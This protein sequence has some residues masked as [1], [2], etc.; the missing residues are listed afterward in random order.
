MNPNNNNIENG[1]KLTKLDKLN[2][3]CVANDKT[4]I[5]N[6]TNVQSLIKSDYF[7]MII[8]RHDFK[9]I[10]NI[11]TWKIS[12][13][14][15][16]ALFDLIM[17]V[18]NGNDKYKHWENMKNYNTDS[19]IITTFNALSYIDFNI[20]KFNELFLI[21]MN[22]ATYK[23][24]SYYYILNNENDK[25]SMKHSINNLFKENYMSEHVKKSIVNICGSLLD[26]NLLNKYEKNQGKYLPFI[27]IINQFSI[28]YSSAC[29]SFEHGGFIFKNH[30]NSFSYPKITTNVSFKLSDKGMKKLTKNLKKKF[31]YKTDIK[32]SCF[33][34]TTNG[35]IEQIS[36]LPSIISLNQL[37]CIKYDILENNQ[38]K[39]TYQE[40]CDEESKMILIDEN[41]SMNLI[42][43]CLEH[44]SLYCEYIYE[45][46]FSNFTKIKYY[47]KTNE[48]LHEMK[49]N[50]VS[51]YR[52]I[53]YDI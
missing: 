37:K 31:Q 46:V 24:C 27:P 33:G 39:C 32:I 38:L 26:N 43:I 51:K 40:T 14:F 4:S 20:D 48:P 45:I 25:Q 52:N 11:K 53:L 3:E 42:S 8:N 36:S 22:H 9:E 2:I 23:Y 18:L 16:F 12:F 35:K 50:D 47:E 28:V 10:D 6:I 41:P 49:T 19:D 29:N 15:N 13:P 30:V 21:I 44:G 7:Q 5:V 1:D 34:I 17:I